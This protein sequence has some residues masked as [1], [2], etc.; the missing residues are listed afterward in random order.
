MNYKLRFFFRIFVIVIFVLSFSCKQSEKTDNPLPNIVFILADDMGYGDPSCYNPDSKIPT[1]NI[2]KLA[3]EGMMFR[4][5]HSAGAWCVPARYGLMTGQ[6]PGRIKLNWQQRSLIQPTQ[7]T[8]AGMLRQNG[9]KTACIGKWHLGFDN[10]NWVEAEKNDILTGGPVER[11]FDYFFGMH[12]SLDIPPY[13]YIENDRLVEKATGFVEDNFSENATTEISGAFWRKGACSPDFKHDE[14]LDVFFEKVEKFVSDHVNQKAEE[15]FFLY[16][17]LTAPHTP[18][19]PKEEFIG[20]SGAGEYGDF[21]M[22]VDVLLG[23]VQ[24]L[25]EEKG[26]K[27]NTLVVFTSD[28]GPV[29]FEEDINKFNHDSKAGLK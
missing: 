23:Q 8:L 9:Y 26:L 21:T 25:L 29:W 24:N 22:Q 3:S 17:P 15:P 19:L 1:P 13:F 2:D 7:E 20:K 12:A 16:L 4:D 5:A 18:W 28:N 27:D 10:I 11:G 14:V 6:Y